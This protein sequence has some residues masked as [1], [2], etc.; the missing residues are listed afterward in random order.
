MIDINRTI[1]VNLIVCQ[2]KKKLRLILKCHEQNVFTNHIYDMY[3]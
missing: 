2:K 3:V 1:R